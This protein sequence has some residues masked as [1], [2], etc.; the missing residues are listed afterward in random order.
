MTNLRAFEAAGRTGSFTAA[1]A[2]LYLTP[3]AVSHAVRKLEQQLGATLFTRE[4][5]A[6]QLTPDGEALMLHVGRG[7][8][9]VRRGIEA[10][11][12]HAPGNLRLH[13]A[14]SFAAQWLSPRLPRFLSQHPGL[15]IRLAAGTDYLQ[16]QSDE[17]DADIVYGLQQ[18]GGLLMLPLGEETITPLCSP[19]LADAIREPRDLL[20]QLLIEGYNRHVRWS[21]WF[22]ANG[23]TALPHCGAR[24]DR[25]FLAI[26]A[27]ADGIGVVL[28]ST[29]LAEREIATGRLVAPLA[30]RA[31]DISL[32]DHHLA[33][34]VIA[35]SRRP[36][37]LFIAWM[38]RELGLKFEP[39]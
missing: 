28:E 16:F 2:E 1:A 35:K 4:G 30:G 21:M 5:R 29:R 25:S 9:E 3:S 26:A 6:V 37:R 15:E 23:L 33:F 31:T 24:F 17:F 34:P 19:K 18:Q 12:T 11:S 27:A 38:E 32:V 7:F 8:E 36:L 22:A 13:C 39:F 20:G 10:V 14:P